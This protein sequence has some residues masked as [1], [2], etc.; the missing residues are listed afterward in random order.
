M[1]PPP[2]GQPSDTPSSFQPQQPG[3]QPVSYGSV[4]DTAP[5]ANAPYN[6]FGVPPYTGDAAASQFSSPQQP[7]YQPTVPVQGSPADGQSAAPAGDQPSPVQGGGQ[8]PFAVPTSQTPDDDSSSTES[9][10]QPDPGFAPGPVPTSSPQTLGDSQTPGN[11]Q[12]PGMTPPNV[13]PTGGQ[14]P[15]GQPPYGGYQQPG[16]PP[17]GQLPYG[18]PMP[19]APKKSN[20]KLV[21]GLSIAGGI[22]ALVVIV[23][24]VL[25][26]LPSGKPTAEDY[27][28]ALNQT[29]KISNRYYSVNTKLSDVYS[30]TYDPS[31]NLDDKDI[32][33]L[34]QKVKDYQSAVSD[35]GSQDKILKDENVKT[36]YDAYVKASDKYASYINGLAD[37]ALPMAKATKACS[38]TPSASLYD[39]DFYDKYNQYIT[40]CTA[41][42]D[43]LSKAKDA[44]VAKYG[45]DMKDYI[46]KLSELIGKMQALGNPN[47]IR[48]GTDQYNQ[49]NDLQDEYYDLSSDGYDIDSDFSD[50][51]KETEDKMNP[52]DELND[53]NDVL[54][55]GFH[56]A[57]SN[58]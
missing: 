33:S 53:L 58:R 11:P 12:T 41:S 14:P 19:P 54:Q 30:V 57:L 38:D 44:D 22:A 15:F 35:L 21:V 20:K 39:S 51:L 4:Q 17:Q 46:G 34:K 47:D 56:D 50:A 6:P 40:D 9:S 31:K 52:E 3:A 55:D 1:T 43:E 13:P 27:T 23:L 36:K 5:G 28:N 18:A 2:F 32:A 8:Q 10:A 24:V 7:Q 49:L 26:F 16:Q 25:A 48:Y 37:S 29:S 45:T 42:L